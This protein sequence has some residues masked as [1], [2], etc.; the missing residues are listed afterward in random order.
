MND[1]QPISALMRS[2]SHLSHYSFIALFANLFASVCVITAFLGVSLCLLDFL[3]DGF[4]VRKTGI[5][6]IFLYALTFAPPLLLVLFGNRVFVYGLS[7][8]GICCVFLLILLPVWMA[9][10]GRYKHNYHSEYQVM[11]GKGM[12]IGLVLVSLVLLVLNCFL[13]RF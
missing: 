13:L 12:L 9:W 2:L 8:A 6:G 11:G 5:P 10:V 7:F 3:A 1:A 4:G